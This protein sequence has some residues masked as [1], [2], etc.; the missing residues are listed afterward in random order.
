MMDVENDFVVVREIGTGIA[1]DGEGEEMETLAEGASL[2][3]AKQSW[4]YLCRD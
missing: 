2:I 1:D 3:W 4:P